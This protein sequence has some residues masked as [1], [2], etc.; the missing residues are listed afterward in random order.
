MTTN[1][2]NMFIL[3]HRF[4]IGIPSAPPEDSGIKGPADD[5]AL[6]FQEEL[7]EQ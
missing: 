5:L 6:A 7:K 4:N 3:I 2:G 1:N